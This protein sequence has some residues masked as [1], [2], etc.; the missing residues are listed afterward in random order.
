MFARARR[1]AV[2]C[3]LVAG[4]SGSHS[5]SDYEG[6]DDPSTGDGDGDGDNGDGDGD[7]GDGDGDRGDGEQGD[8]D[9]EQGVADP[10]GNPADACGNGGEAL[11]QGISI[12][13]ISLYQVVKIPIVQNGEWLTTRVAPIVANKKSLMRVFVNTEGGFSPHA[14]R[15]VLTL[16][17]G[18]EPK[19]LVDKAKPQGSSVE[20]DAGS[21]FNFQIDAGDITEN[22]R[23][24]VALVENTCPDELGSASL[25][26]FPH[27][28]DKALQARHI[29]K[30]RVQVVPVQ[31]ANGIIPST[32]AGQL[33]EM[34]KT[35][36]AYYPVSDIEITAHAPMQSDRNPGPQ[37][38]DWGELLQDIV[39]LRAQEGAPADL[40]YY[41]LI[42]PEKDIGVFC[43]NGC[44]LGLAPGQDENNPNAFLRGALGIGYEHPETYLTIVHEVA[45]THGRLHAPC[46]PPPGE[47]QGI[48]YGYPNDTADTASYGWDSRTNELKPPTSKDFMSYCRPTWISAYN[49]AAL[50]KR[51]QLVNKALTFSETEW[52]NLLVTPSGSTWSAHRTHFAPQGAT[53]TAFVKDAAGKTL[54]QIQV[55]RHGLSDV[56]GTFVTLPT[57]EANWATVVLHDREIALSKVRAP[58]RGLRPISTK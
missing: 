35:F 44:T 25:A 46:V 30:L 18:G 52:S 33:E 24:S 20:T 14:M 8:G 50:A 3:L 2:A 28:G 4:C 48:D 13:E 37:G 34:R 38:Q 16:D 11:A 1:F 43:R 40:Y 42:T 6:S 36:L 9:G 45:H 49:Y 12:S 10:N 27:S 26:R 56:E 32:T 19:W 47:I 54:K 15:A 5:G 57:P 31:L 21:T 51:S 7:H 58:S 39:T 22:T 41:G 55:Q 23:F 53:E 29:G 17:N